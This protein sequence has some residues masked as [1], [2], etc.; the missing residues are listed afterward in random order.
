MKKKKK[1]A[2]LQTEQSDFWNNPLSEQLFLMVCCFIFIIILW[3]FYIV[4]MLFLQS[5]YNIFMIFLQ[6]FYI[7]FIFFLYYL[8]AG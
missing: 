8:Y 5:F 3:I 2:D 1:Q 4:F 6:S 7:I